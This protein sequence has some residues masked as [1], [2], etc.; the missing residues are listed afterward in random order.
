M[1]SLKRESR[2]PQKAATTAGKTNPDAEAKWKAEHEKLSTALSKTKEEYEGKLKEKDSAF[3]DYKMNAKMDS[4]L[5][6]QKWSEHIPANMRADIGRLALQKK[7]DEAGAKAILGEDGE[8]KLV[9]KDNNDMPYFDSSNKNPKFTEF[10]P[11]VLDENK[12]L[13]ASV[14]T[15]PPNKHNTF[16]PPVPNPSGTPANT[17]KRPDATLSALQQSIKDQLG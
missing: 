13:A 14:Q 1:K 11:K 16:T 2:R 12:F 3:Y 15:P 5:S 9:R 10:A 7:M 8:I 6:A 17:N 4:I